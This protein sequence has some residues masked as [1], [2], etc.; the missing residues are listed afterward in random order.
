MLKNRGKE[1]IMFTKRFL[2]R[3]VN[4]FINQRTGEV[5]TFGS[6][7]HKDS[8]RLKDGDTCPL[9]RLCGEDV[10]IIMRNGNHRIIKQCVKLA[11]RLLIP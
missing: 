2:K 6:I 9:R 8:Q 3:E 1:I 5:G 7:S 4:E 10:Y 11:F